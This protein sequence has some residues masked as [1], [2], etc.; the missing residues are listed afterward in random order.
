MTLSE[1]IDSK[2]L[3][4]QSKTSSGKVRRAAC[5]E[6]YEQGSLSASHRA[7]WM[8]CEESADELAVSDDEMDLNEGRRVP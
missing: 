7:P 3:G 5:R 6:A 2:R 4:I 8:K 1:G